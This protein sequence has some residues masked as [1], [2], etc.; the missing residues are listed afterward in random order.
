V[1][2]HSP[3][4]PSSDAARAVMR[5]NRSADTVPELA[6]RRALHRRGLRFRVHRQVLESLRCRP[7]VVFGPARVAVFVMG[8]FWHRCPEHGA[9]PQANRDYWAAKFA[10]N[11]ARD[12][13]N[14]DAL[15]HAGWHVVWVWEHERPDAA[16]E[17]LEAVVRSRRT[18]SR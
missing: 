10:R 17:R 2:R 3:P 1:R 7:D 4:E 6:L 12:R 13:R 9:L 5:G 8:C 16:A 15:E 11:V 14:R 18:G